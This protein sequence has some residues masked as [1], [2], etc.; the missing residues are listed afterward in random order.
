MV[1]WQSEVEDPERNDTE[2]IIRRVTDAIN[3]DR[4]VQLQRTKQS[5]YIYKWF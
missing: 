3:T 2:D 4:G 1:D 5:Y